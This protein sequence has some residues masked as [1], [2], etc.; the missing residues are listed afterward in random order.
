MLALREKSVKLTGYLEFLL[1]SLF[2][3]A[4]F[5]IITPRDISDRGAQLSLRFQPGVMEK[6]KLQLDE[7][8]IIVDERKPDVI[9]IAPV[10]LYNTFVEVWHFATILREIMNDL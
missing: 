10:P 1:D 5:S 7:R 2:S 3:E 9:R 4:L 6:V 8:K